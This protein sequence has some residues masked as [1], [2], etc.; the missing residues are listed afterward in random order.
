[1]DRPLLRGAP[2][3]GLAL[4]PHLLGPALIT[5]IV[6]FANV[7]GL[8]HMW[9]FVDWYDNRLQKSLEA[10]LEFLFI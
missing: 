9:N 4:G 3:L 6:T 10:L 7:R 2:R 1:M 8:S 5:N